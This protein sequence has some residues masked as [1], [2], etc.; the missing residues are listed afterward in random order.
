MRAF[1]TSVTLYGG[2]TFSQP[3]PPLTGLAAADAY[4]ND[5]ADSRLLDGTWRAFLSTSFVNAPDRIIG[6]GPWVNLDGGVVIRDRQELR[7]G[8]LGGAGISIETGEGPLSRYLFWT[9]TTDGGVA[10]PNATCS[11]WVG[12][13]TGAAGTTQVGV[14]GWSNQLVEAC[15]QANR[16]LCLEQDLTPRRSSPRPTNPRRLFVT[17]DVMSGNRGGL[18]GADQTCQ[19]FA[20][21]G[22]LT[23]T[24]RALLATST[25]SPLARLTSDGPFTLLDGGVVF[26]N[27]A[28]LGLGQT[29]VRLTDETGFPTGRVFWSGANSVAGS[30]PSTCQDWTSSASANSAFVGEVRMLSG[31]PNNVSSRF[32]WSPSAG[33]CN[34]FKYLLCVEQ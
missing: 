11:D 15:S 3:M 19:T 24:W 14:L 30:T 23:G 17:S 21:A 5:I 4:C 1:V 7:F 31:F 29:F 6:A 20:L 9:G 25:Q 18:S 28:A 33:A 8:A 12:I 13:G 32:A 16:L 10:S 26:P 34:T 27:R 22:N 2:L